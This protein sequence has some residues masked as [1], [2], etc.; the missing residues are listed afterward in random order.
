MKH[1]G[2]TLPYFDLINVAPGVSA[3]SKVG[4]SRRSKFC[5][6]VAGHRRRFAQTFCAQCET[7]KISSHRVRFGVA[8][9]SS[10]T[11]NMEV[12]VRHLVGDRHAIV[13]SVRSRRFHGSADQLSASPR[14]VLSE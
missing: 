8:S 2:Q 11:S 3:T 10:G 7:E 5:K 1:A 12:P 13:T 6:S 4:Q 14:D 9:A